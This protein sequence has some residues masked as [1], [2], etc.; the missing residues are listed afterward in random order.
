M[1]GWYNQLV[2]PLLFRM[3]P[4]TAHHFALRSLRWPG[5]RTALRSFAPPETPVSL[6]GLTFRNPIGLAA[7]TSATANNWAGKP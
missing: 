5:A 3:D 2:R 1:S 7:V 6:F 4:E